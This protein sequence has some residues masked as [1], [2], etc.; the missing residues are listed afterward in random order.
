M[1]LFNCC[2]YAMV[3]AAQCLTRCHACCATAF[4]APVAG[5]LFAVEFVLKSNRLGLD[6]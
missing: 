3:A 5:A 4:D 1:V 2:S 6:R